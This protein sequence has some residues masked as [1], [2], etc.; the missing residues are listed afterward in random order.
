VTPNPLDPARRLLRTARGV[1]GAVAE[2][3]TGAASVLGPGHWPGLLGAIGQRAAGPGTRVLDA[4]GAARV[5][6]A[7]G[8][9]APVRPDRL[10]GMGLALRYGTS[11]A[12]GLA[13]AAARTPGHVG[14]IDDEGSLTYRELGHRTDALAESYALRGVTAGTAVGLLARNGRG[15]LE[16]LV[17]LSKIG[18]DVVL[19]NTGMAAPQLADVVRREVLVAAA[20]DDDLVSLLPEGLAR[21][22]S[23]ATPIGRVSQRTPPATPGRIVLLTSGTTG[24]PKGAARTVRG[25]G[26]G[27]AMLEAIPYRAGEPLLIASPMFHAWGIANLAARARRRRPRGA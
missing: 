15:F 13:A 6:A 4:A 2:P 7:A 12:A 26:P 1:A 17:A 19:L 3:V 18:A 27:I 20:C 22:D 5:L 25:A 9:L 11:I 23:V 10:V 16:P 24:T 14:L 8:V 21:L